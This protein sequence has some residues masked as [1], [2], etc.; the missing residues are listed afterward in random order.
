MLGKVGALLA[1]IVGMSCARPPAEERP[2]RHRSEEQPMHQQTAMM[3]A[4]E[5]LL[6]FCWANLNG[7]EI[8]AGAATLTVLLVV[9]R[10]PLTAES[11]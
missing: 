11:G 3:V 5:E 2:P 7:W 6:E 9:S 8:F 4:E 1:L 10:R